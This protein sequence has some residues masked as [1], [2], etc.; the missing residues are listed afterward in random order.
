MHENTAPTLAQTERKPWHEI[1]IQ[2]TA[3]GWMWSLRTYANYDDQEGQLTD[4]SATYRTARDAAAAAEAEIAEP[5][6]ALR[7]A[8]EALDAMRNPPTLRKPTRRARY[9]IEGDDGIFRPLTRHG[10][11]FAATMA[12]GSTGYWN[13][14]REARADHRVRRYEDPIG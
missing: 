4:G 9:E 6:R 1:T 13:S 3:R 10:R 14:L 12:P 7:I 5:G 11:G 2:S 8:R